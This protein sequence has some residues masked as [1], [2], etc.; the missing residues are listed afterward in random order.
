VEGRNRPLRGTGSAIR[1]WGYC[2]CKAM[3]VLF[4]MSVKIGI[5]IVL[6]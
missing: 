2:H 3:P 1:E 5:Q 6:P 4:G